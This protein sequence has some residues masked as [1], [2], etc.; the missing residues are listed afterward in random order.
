MEY[1]YSKGPRNM[2]SLIQAVSIFTNTI[3]ATISETLVPLYQDPSLLT[4]V[5][6]TI[7]I[8]QFWGQDRDED[9]L[10]NLPEGDVQASDHRKGQAQA[11]LEIAEVSPGRG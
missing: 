7:L 3:S 6:G 10:N 1:V 8:L 4:F 2:R 5:G 9:M 11:Q